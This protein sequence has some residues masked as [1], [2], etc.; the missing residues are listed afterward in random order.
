MPRPVACRF[1]TGPT[2]RRNARR[3]IAAPPA[4]TPRRCL[5]PFFQI[6]M[7][8]PADRLVLA[9]GV[10]VDTANSGQGALCAPLCSLAQC[11]LL[12]AVVGDLDGIAHIDNT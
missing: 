1:A 5:A 9:I 10:T 8:Q 6:K 4:L 3:A 2:G 11:P 12:Q 7:P